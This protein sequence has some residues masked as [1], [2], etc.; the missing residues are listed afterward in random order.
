MLLVH[1]EL[2]RLIWKYLLLAISG[3]LRK[4]VVHWVLVSALSQVKVLAESHFIAH[5]YRF[6]KFFSI[7][8]AVIVE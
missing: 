5:I 8:L 4:L 6:E 1:N 2:H 7:M 3:A